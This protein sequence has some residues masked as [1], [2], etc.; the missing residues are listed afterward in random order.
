MLRRW[1]ILCQL[2]S[3]FNAYCLVR[4][5]SNSLETM[6]TIIGVYFWLKSTSFQ[7]VTQPATKTP[8]SWYHGKAGSTEQQQ[9]DAAWQ[10]ADALREQKKSTGI[11]ASSHAVRRGFSPRQI[12]LIAAAFGVLVRP[13]SVLFWL[14]QGGHLMLSLPCTMMPAQ[15]YMH[16]TC[17]APGR[18]AWSQDLPA[19]HA[20]SMP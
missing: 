10:P 5:Y 8:S 20:K 18:P 1:T 9:S 14:P 12:A 17:H 11:M 4:T 19:K 7:H 16:L 2:A 15:Q 13:S 6:C 3:W